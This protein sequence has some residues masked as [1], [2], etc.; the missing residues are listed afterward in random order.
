MLDRNKMKQALAARKALQE[1]VIDVVS[2]GVHLRIRADYKVLSVEIDGVKDDRLRKAL[3]K[4]LKEMLKVQAKK[5]KGMMGN[6]N[7]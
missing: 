4:A 7:Q 2:S 6:F 1:E 3:N 5:L